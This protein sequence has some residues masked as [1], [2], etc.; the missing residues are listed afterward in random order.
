MFKDRSQLKLMTKNRFNKQTKLS[1][2]LNK[3]AD[4]VLIMSKISEKEVHPSH[5]FKFIL[6]ASQP[7]H[8]LLTNTQFHPSQNQKSRFFCLPTDNNKTVNEKT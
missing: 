2:S 3:I 4:R 8:L 5:F 7:A 1:N 6:P